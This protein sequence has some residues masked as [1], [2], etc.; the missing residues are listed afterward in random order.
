VQIVDLIRSDL[1]SCCTP[2]TVA[3]PKLIA[4][5]SYGVHNLVTTVRGK[6]APN[7]GTVEAVKRCFP[8]GE[9]RVDRHNDD[10]AIRPRDLLG[11]SHCG[12]A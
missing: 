4:L 7:V 6:L 5:E 8:P 2:S 1:L 10:D 12:A 11:K 9:W 3:V